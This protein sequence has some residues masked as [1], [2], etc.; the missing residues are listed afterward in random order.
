VKD[1]GSEQSAL[2]DAAFRRRDAKLR[3][4]GRRVGSQEAE[5]LYQDAFVKIVERSQSEHI[6]KLDNLLRHVVRC[7]TIDRSRRRASRPTFTSDEAGDNVVDAIADPERQV[8]GTQ[9]LKRVLAAI[10]A[11]PPKRREVF[12]LHRVDDLTYAQIARRLDVSIRTVE[13]HFALAMR[14][15]SD[16]DD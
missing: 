11:M 15:L 14:Q 5:D 13:K 7:L 4:I 9:R 6:P 8:I 12:L 10:D 1:R 3:D 2:V 16:T